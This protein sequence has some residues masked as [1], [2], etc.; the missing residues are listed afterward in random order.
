MGQY[1]VILNL[2]PGWR[3]GRRSGLKISVG[4]TTRPHRN[5]ARLVEKFT[6]PTRPQIQPDRGY[7]C[8]RTSG[9]TVGNV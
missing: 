9:R 1:A 8:G 2:T 7:T 4:H 5:P 3:N 6:L